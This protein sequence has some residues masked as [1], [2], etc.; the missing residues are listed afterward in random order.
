MRELA[1][2]DH[3]ALYD[4][5]A[6]TSV[7]AAVTKIL[8]LAVQTVGPYRITPELASALLPA[9]REYLLRTLWQMTFSNRIR[10]VLTCPGCGITMDADCEI[11]ALSVQ[12]KPQ[13]RSYAVSLNGSDVVFRLP[14]SADIELVTGSVYDGLDRIAALLARCVISIGGRTEVTEDVVAALPPECR[15]ALELAIEEASPDTRVEF[16][17]SCPECDRR[18]EADFDVPANFLAE[19]HRTRSELLQG[20]HLLSFHYHWSLREILGLS[21]AA[22]RHYVR[23]LVTNLGSTPVVEAVSA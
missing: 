1:G 10:S 22:R 20:I 8:V 3:M 9:D 2:R 14:Q 15:S 11:D 23:L 12:P 16:E 21:T 18:F 19:L 4:L 7:A 6:Q 5:P 13:Q 17:A